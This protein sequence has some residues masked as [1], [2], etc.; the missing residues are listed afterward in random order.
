MVPLAGVVY[1]YLCFPG[2]WTGL[3]VEIAG[4]GRLNCGQGV[5]IGEGSRIDLP[6]DSRLAL[7]P[8]VIIGRDVYLWLVP[9]MT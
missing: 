7:G 4:Q 1:N 8:G 3:R 2:L 5:R 6:P 9:V